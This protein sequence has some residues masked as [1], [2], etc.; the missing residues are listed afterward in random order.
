MIVVIHHG[1]G[2]NTTVDKMSFPIY[3]PFPRAQKCTFFVTEL[4]HSLRIR[5]NISK[6]LFVFAYEFVR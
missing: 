4:I 3:L 1:V 5:E 6:T 2:R